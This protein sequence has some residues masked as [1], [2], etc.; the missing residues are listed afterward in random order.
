MGNA[1][2]GEVVRAAEVLRDA[3]PAR[4]RR[5]VWSRPGRAHIEVRGLLGGTKQRERLARGLESA[6]AELS[7]VRWARVNAALGHVVVDATED[8]FDLPGLLDVVCAV[9]QAHGVAKQPFTRDRPNAAFD[10]VPEMLAKVALV[11]DCVGLVGTLMGWTASIAWLPGAVRVPLIV[12]DT[13]PQV[14]RW[15]VRRVGHAHADAFLAA[16]GALVYS[17]TGGMTP[18]VLDA[19]QQ[20]FKLG[21]ARSRQAV[22]ERREDEFVADGTGLPPQTAE[23]LPRPGAMPAGP[24]EKCA[25]QT[26]LAALLGAAG[27]AAWTR[28]AEQAGRALLATVPKAAGAGRE[29]FCSV[30]GRD[31]AQTGV[32]PMNPAALRRLDRVS[33]VVIDSPALCVPRVRLLSVAAG[34]KQ[35]EAELWQA[36]QK[37]LTGLTLKDMADPGPWAAGG[38]RL[39]RGPDSLDQRPDAESGLHLEVH[40]M[41]GRGLGRIVV[42]CDLDPL[43]DAVIAAAR[44]GDRRL[45]MTRHSSV[46]EL[47]RWADYA[48]PPS[49]TLA[50]RV[51]ALQQDGHVVALITCHDGEALAAAD[52]GVALLLPAAFP[53]PAPAALWSADLVCGP[54][55]EHVWRVLS[56]VDAAHQVSVASARLSMGGSALGALIAAAGARRRMWG[57]TMSPVHCAMF[58]AQ[59]G[60]VRAARRLARRPCPSGHVRGAWHA[61]DADDAFQLLR[62][63]RHRADTAL[64][65]SDGAAPTT[66]GRTRRQLGRATTSVVKSLGLTAQ[67]QHAGELFGAVCE[68][69]RDPLTPVLALGA[70]ASAAV[71]SNIDSLLVGGVMAGNAV[72]SGTQRMR[73]EQALKA[74][75][76]HES[77]TAHR[78]RRALDSP[79]QD[80][81]VLLETADFDPVD[82]SDLQV[83]DVIALHPSEVVPADARLLACDGLEVDEA[84]LTGEPVPV[85]KHPR[86]IP[87]A[88]LAER[89]CMVYQGCTVLAGTGMAIVVATGGQTEAG[90]AGDLAGNAISA[91]GIEGQLAAL[92]RAALPVV[93]IGGAAVTTLGLLRGLPVRQALASGVAVA[94][95][96]VPEGL[97]LVATVAQSAAARRLSRYGILP[98]S[99]RTLEALGRVD[100][101]CFDKTGTLT[102]G[103]LTLTRLA[104]AEEIL[105]PDA[106]EARRLLRT[107]ARACPAADAPVAHA[108]DRAVLEAA[109]KHEVR[110]PDWA[111]VAELPF[112]ASRGYSASV[113]TDAGRPALAVKGAPEV[114]LQRCTTALE[115]VTGSGEDPDDEAGSGHRLVPLDDRRLA[116]AHRMMR[117]L[118]DQGLRVLAVAQA[119]VPPV[120]P[121]TDDPGQAAA[122]A[123]NTLRA[124]M[125]DHLVHDLTLLGFLAIADA[126]RRTAADAVKRLTDAGVRIVMITGDHPATAAA[127]A[128]DLGIP[129]TRTIVTGADIDSLTTSDC[130]TAIEGAGLFARVSPEHKVRIV[131]ALQQAGHVVAMTGDG[132]NDA[133]AIRL[134]DIGIGIGTHGSTAARAAADLVL[135]E[136]DLT[137]I[138]DALHEGRALWA[139]IRDAVA[140][141]VGGNAGEVAF[142]ILGTALAGRAPLGTR[143][144][145][146]VNLL[147]DMLP[148]LA[149]ALAHRTRATHTA[150]DR[151]APAPMGPALARLL[152]IR[153]T[154]T[155][156]AAALAWQTGRFTGRA[157]RADTMGL[158]A[159][160]TAQLGQTLITDWRSPLVLATTGI[161]T[162]ALLTAVQT[163]GL[164]QFFGCTPLGPIAWATV[165]ASATTA[166]FGAAL[167]PRLFT[168]DP[169]SPTPAA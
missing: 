42:G 38:W 14:R 107:A 134:A 26:S 39:T 78:L 84:A 43:A 27:V 55:L 60:G 149:V 58:L 144:L 164:S 140:I 65:T 162:T 115:S 30:L 103:R 110:D 163:P 125:L 74:L 116:A 82:A 117:Q 102:E 91:S 13:Q 22:W 123:G 7:G 154:A 9:E 120:G 12:A 101:I 57:L 86:A 166:T 54:G 16:A 10:D 129:R 33:A 75:L 18:L 41:D 124:D 111:R 15:L 130:T 25:E 133:A 52:V 143:Q 136:P 4:L 126:P 104:S 34:R 88:D 139:S 19:L 148:A 72:I 146:L 156:L 99:A 11:S 128:G 44:A 79:G 8:G 81:H 131:R 122:Q 2:L 161:S 47:L 73:A 121:S 165:A 98:R 46:A 127:I 6:L 37:V 112:E 85:A 48:V 93:G 67:A 45:E 17:I 152:A 51:R 87:G 21:E 145:L 158:A 3:G 80:F 159:L 118:A 153:G 97:P 71:G 92:T 105:P 68:E 63:L 94:V 76:T 66:L 53:G 49:T 29:A 31:L 96:A 157:R 132:V 70:A 23:P 69:L 106:E 89:S 5:T 90:R 56:A 109:E 95:A 135:T 20:W 77:I 36:A 147:T 167:A 40:D 137:R 59:V 100:V 114:V 108:T 28:N 24:V 155:A 160:I 138:L 169:P 142:T 150:M 32:V 35:D 113:G 168:T 1:V 64:A 50:D 151:P 119:A 141:L 61:M 83:G 62:P